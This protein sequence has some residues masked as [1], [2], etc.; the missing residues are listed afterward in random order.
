[1]S[2]AKN[3]DSLREDIRQQGIEFFLASFVEITGASKAKLVPAEHI[4]GLMEDGAGFAGFAAGELGQ[5]PHD[6]DIAA[7]P[8]MDSLT[9]LP[10]QP[11][12]GWLA[13]D[14][15]VNGEPW[16]YCP[17][18]ILKKLREE[19]RNEGFE[20]RMGVEPEFF[21]V[22]RNVTG[23]EPADPLDRLAKPCYDQTTLT[24]SLDF[25]TTIIKYMQQLGWDPYANDHE[26]ANCQF[27]INWSYAECLRTADRHTFFKYMVKVLAEKNGAVATFMPKPFAH[28]TGSGAHLHISLW[29]IETGKNVF[30][31]K[32][33]ENGMSQSALHFIGGLL[34]HARGLSALTSPT[35]NSYKRLVSGA[36]RSGAT[37]APVHICYGGNNRTQMLRIPAPG[38]IENRAVDG[39]ANPYLAAAG[40][41]AAGLDGMRNKIDPGP[42]NDRNMYDIPP[43]DYFKEDFQVLPASLKEAVA[44]LEADPVLMAA[45]GPEYGPTSVAAKRAEWRS[46]HNSVSNWEIENYLGVY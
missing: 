5:Q 34:K 11:N 36:P 31:D 26:D 14:I 33:N 38:R 15:H 19:A 40:I 8:D 32:D 13:G 30:L 18:T 9:V 37:W 46:Y 23:I 20:M 17:R 6:P 41:L 42:R 22:K 10:W 43:E 45:L 3:L 24:R 35:V 16:P 12:I 27:E 44:D 28:L 39:S 29:D 25:L 4:E 1:M 21:L 7:I 2:T